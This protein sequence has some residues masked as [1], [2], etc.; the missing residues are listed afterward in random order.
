MFNFWGIIK[1][2]SVTHKVSNLSTSLT[3]CDNMLFFILSYLLL[4]ILANQVVPKWYL[5]MIL[6]CSILM[7]SEVEHTSYAYWPFIYFCSGKYLFKFPKNLD[8]VIIF[9]HWVIR[10]LCIFSE[11]ENLIK[12]MIMKIYFFCF[13]CSWC[14]AY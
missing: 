4:I 12:H 13:S 6:I 5:I 1:V 2:S 7:N 3:I 11:Y 9:G 14:Y 10:V 8:Y